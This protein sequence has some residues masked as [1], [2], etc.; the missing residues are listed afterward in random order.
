MHTGIRTF[1]ELS[2]PVRTEWL[3][4]GG[5]SKLTRKTRPNELSPPPMP[6]LGDGWV[7]LENLWLFYHGEVS[8]ASHRG[9]CARHPEPSTAP[10]PGRSQQR[11]I[12]YSIAPTNGGER[13]TGDGRL[14]PSANR[15]FP[16]PEGLPL[17]G[18][19]GIQPS[20]TFFP[21]KVPVRMRT[22]PALQLL[23]YIC[24]KIFAKSPFPAGFVFFLFKLDCFRQVLLFFKAFFRHFGRKLSGT[25]F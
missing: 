23:V 19:G 2:D 10:Q 5:G 17:G 12:L 7:G 18:K 13:N 8:A 22:R 24:N 15:S 6:P 21:A 11:R 1:F 16:A 9:H 4:L 3:N 14:S 25:F 20:D